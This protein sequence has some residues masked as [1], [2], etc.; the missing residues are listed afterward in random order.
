MTEYVKVLRSSDLTLNAVGM[1][2]ECYRIYEAMACGSVPVIEDRPPA[3]SCGTVVDSRRVILALLKRYLAPVIYVSDWNRLPLILQAEREMSQAAIAARRRKVVR[4]YARFRRIMRDYFVNVLQVKF[5]SDG[6]D[7]LT[8][9]MP[10]LQPL[11][12]DVT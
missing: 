6:D 5:F 4:W 3:D 1:N 11:P 12:K 7:H 9:K 10:P 2:A 8:F